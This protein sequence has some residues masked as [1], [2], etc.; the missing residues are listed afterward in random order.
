L[1]L[2]PFI[3]ASALV[4][5]LIP[6]IVAQTRTVSLTIDDLPFVTGADLAPVDA[7]EAIKANRQLI[8]ALI[9]HHI[10]VTGFVIQRNVGTLGQ[11]SG[12]AIL[13]DWIKHGLDLGN[14]TYSHPE[15]D[16]LA[17]EQFESQIVRGE[18]TFLPLTQLPQL[19]ACA[20]YFE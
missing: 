8:R 7:G 3:A 15:F 1:R 13:R 16:H 20:N 4:I 11:D 18:A 9:R 5:N 6:G 14:H 10:P 2:L 17:V 12:T 19:G